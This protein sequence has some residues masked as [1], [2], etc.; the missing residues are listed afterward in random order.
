MR[1]V[2]TCGRFAVIF[3]LLLGAIASIA[4]AQDGA[5]KFPLFDYIASEHAA[6]IAYTPSELDPRNPA[7]QERLATASLRKDLEALRPAFDGLVL[8]GYNEA[9]TPRLVAVAK[10][11]KYRAILLAIWQPKSAAECDGV[12]ELAK[13]HEK[14]FAL[15]VLVGNE[16]LT[17]GRYEEEDVR[18]AGERLR[19]KLPASVP[20]ATTEPLVGYSRKIMLEFGDFLCPNIHPVFDRKDLAAPAAA[21]WVHEEARK[22]ASASGKHVIVKET[23]FPHAG[24]AK[25]T[26]ATQADFWQAYAGDSRLTAIEGNSKNTRLIFTGIAFEAFDLPWKA[27]ASGL[28]IEKS[29]GLMSHDRKPYAAFDV[30]RKLSE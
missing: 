7:N 5:K 14:D 10:D 28:A 30:W 4:T 1:V 20:I 11:L 17:F 27:E 18:I 21:K 19:A 3:Y 22:L 23:G 24:D 29:W 2:L 12:A 6:M 15:G 25:Y 9:S 8:Y 13:L 26:P 16:G